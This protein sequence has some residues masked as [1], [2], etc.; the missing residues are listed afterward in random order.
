MVTV[1]IVFDMGR[2][3]RI[4]NIEKRIWIQCKK[5]MLTHTQSILEQAAI[6]FSI[7]PIEIHHERNKGDRG[8][9]ERMRVNE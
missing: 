4:Y 1:V 3:G 6:P 5:P 9:N 2:Y 8:R 7:K